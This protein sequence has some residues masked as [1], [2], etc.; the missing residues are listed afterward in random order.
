MKPIFT[1]D[2]PEGCTS[3]RGWCIFENHPDQQ[4]H[5]D[6]SRCVGFY[7]D[8]EGTSSHGPDGETILAAAYIKRLDPITRLTGEIRLGH[9]WFRTI[10]EAKEL[11][12]SN[13]CAYFGKARAAA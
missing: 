6:I 13:I 3:P 1:W 9:C 12:E 5:P 8:Y 10:A 4:D 2:E 7:L 11:I